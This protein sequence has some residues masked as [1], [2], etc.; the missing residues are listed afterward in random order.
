MMNFKSLIVV[1][2]GIAT[3]GLAL[4]AHAGDTGT[5]VTTKQD[6]FVTGD[7]NE[8]IQN[9]QTSV[10]NRERGSHQRSSSST[11]TVVNSNQSAD[12]AGDD[13]LT[14]QDDSTTV[15]NDRDTRRAR[16]YHY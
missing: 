14:V 4:P 5:V 9:H 7:G 13:N 11:G 1:G 10:S 2:L 6:V 8:T 3:L 16:R 12:V 15:N